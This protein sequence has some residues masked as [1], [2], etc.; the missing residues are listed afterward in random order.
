MAKTNGQVINFDLL[1]A[2]AGELAIVSAPITLYSE[3]FICPKDVTFGFQYKFRSGG[4]VA[5]DIFID[6]GNTPPATEGAASVNL[7]TPD[8]ASALVADAA[9]TLRHVTAYAPIVTNFFRL[10]VVGKGANAATT[11]LEEFIIN[12]IVNA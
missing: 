8:G 12:T 4:T 11:V 10:R 6:Q 1:A 2:G 7:V 3:T 5:V 9:D